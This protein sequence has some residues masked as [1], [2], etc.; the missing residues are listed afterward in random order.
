MDRL[1]ALNPHP[2]WALN[3]LGD[4][5]PLKRPR[6]PQDESNPQGD[7]LPTDRPTTG[8]PGPRDPH[9]RRPPNH[10]RLGPTRTRAG[11][12]FRKARLASGFTQK[13]IGIVLGM[14]QQAISMWE[15]G[16]ATIP[17][18]RIAK[19]LKL[20]PDLNR[21]ELIRLMVLD[22]EISLDA[23]IPRVRQRRR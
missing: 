15:V 23:R 16:R 14:D 8:R 17:R 5:M 13:I 6:M 4:H 12:Y 10:S 1:G 20:L 7:A 22:L 18:K 21:E 3:Q 9:A 11:K 2:R 19:L